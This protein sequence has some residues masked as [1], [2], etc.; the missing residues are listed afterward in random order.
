M[1][2]HAIVELEEG[3][4]N[5]VVG[6]RDGGRTR[7]VRSVRMPL[8]DLT[9][10]SIENAL[11]TV[12]SDLLQGA[13]GVHVILGDRRSQHFLSTIPKMPARDAEAFVTREALRLA[14]IQSADDILVTT[15]L[16]RQLAG[17]K[18]VLGSA[19]LGRSIWEPV[20]AAFEN[21][22]L[23][24]LSLQTME[25]CLAMATD[26]WHAE[27]VALLECNGARAR[28]VVCVDQTAVTVRRFMISGGGLQNEATLMTQLA[29][30]L[31]RTMVWLRES[32]QKLPS[33]LLI[34]SRVG[35]ADECLQM[36]ANDEVGELKRAVLEVDCDEDL[37]TPSMGVG[38]LLNR[39]ANGANAHSLLDRSSL[40]LPMGKRHFVTILAAAGVAVLGGYSAVVDGSAWLRT[41]GER[42]NV[43]AQCA[44]VQSQLEELAQGA[45]QSAVPSNHPLLTAAMNMRRPV[46][47]LISEV[48]NSA[49]AGISLD[50]IKFASESPIVL[51]GQVEGASRQQALAAMGEF[52]KKVHAMPFVMANGQDEMSEVI[53]RP[54]R[55]RFKLSL[56]WRNQ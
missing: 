27:P 5:V 9:T 55:F 8:A 11:R 2:M 44:D 6:G 46:S 31:P 29:M 14:N 4:L 3:T 42:D 40:Q 25:S 17:G 48:S 47:R 19:A 50:E 28:Y 24:V 52:T 56:S 13:Q 45:T 36:L 15:R 37:S 16:V 10:G 43:S 51:S 26:A 23:E 22:N 49:P 38:S 54:N 39:L 21:C 41:G 33:R 7:V 18:L 20:R 34:G 12:G 35:L 32:G 53:G 30:E 1:K